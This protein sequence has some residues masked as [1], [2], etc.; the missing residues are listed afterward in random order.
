MEEVFIACCGQAAPNLVVWRTPENVRGGSGGANRRFPTLFKEKD[1]N[2]Q[3][4][5]A[6]IEEDAYG[7]AANGIPRNSSRSAV[8]FP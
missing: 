4:R 1:I 7:G 6:K 3:C 2:C 5:H 8:A